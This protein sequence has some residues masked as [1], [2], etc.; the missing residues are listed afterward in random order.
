MRR[1]LVGISTI[2]CLSLQTRADI[3]W[4]EKE[5]DFGL[6]KEE[7]GPKTGYARFVNTGP[8][9]V[10][11]TGM[12]PRCGCTKADFPKDPIAAG[13]TATV[14]FTYDPTGRPGKFNK[15]VRVYIGSS[16]TYK[17]PITGNVL[18]TP[19]SLSTLYPVVSGPQWPRL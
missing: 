11:I 4:I 16:E 5:Y 10:M 13:D 8:E 18:G 2:L 14:S 15:S 3:V 7:A 6:I 1:T 9:E 12:R 19:Q 17:I